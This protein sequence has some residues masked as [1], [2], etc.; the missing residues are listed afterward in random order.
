MKRIL[1]SVLAVATMATAYA[2]Q[3]KVAGNLKADPAITVRTCGT[4]ELPLEYETWLANK[5]AAK[6]QPH[7]NG[8]HHS[9]GNTCNS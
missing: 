6:C 9:G 8:L 2:Q 1:L 4:A 5:M 7:S 3:R